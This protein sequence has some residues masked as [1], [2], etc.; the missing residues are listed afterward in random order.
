M[1]PFLFKSIDV[2]SE[3]IYCSTSQVKLILRFEEVNSQI[4]VK[5]ILSL[6]W[7]S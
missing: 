2:K 6:G 7:L 1:P 3:F 5:E 4:G